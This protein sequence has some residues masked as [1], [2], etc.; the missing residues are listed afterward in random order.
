MAEIGRTGLRRQGG[1][2]SEEFLQE[3][4]GPRGRRA[5]REMSSNDAVVGA[6]LFAIEQLSRSVSWR[7]EPGGKAPEDQER[8]AFVEGCLDDMSSTWSDTLSEILS[9]LT[10]GFSWHE[11]VYKR[12][13][14]E[15]R[16]AT[17]RSAFNDGRIGWRKWPIRSQDSL[18]QWV[19]D[20]EGGVQGF[21]QQDP[22]A[23]RIV[24]IPIE[25][26]LLFRTASRKANPEGTSVLRT[27]Y[28][29]WYFSR[30]IEEIEAI[31]VSRDL[32]GY[33]VMQVLE[34]GPDIWNANDAAAV[35]LK[36]NIETLVRSISR[37]EQEGMVLPHW[38]E[39]KLVSSGSRRNFDTSGIIQRY[40]QRIAASMLADFILLG[41]EKVGSF[42]L[43]SSKT[44]L[45]AT[46][47]GSY[48]DAIRDVVNRHAIPRLLALNGWPT[49][50][51]PKLAHGDVE[52]PD[53]AELGTYVSSLAGAG[54]PLFPDETLER[55]LRAAA[56]LPEPDPD[57]EPIVEPDPEP[58]PTDPDLGPADEVEVDDDG[59]PV[60]PAEKR[61]RKSFYVHGLKKHG[62]HDQQSHAGDGD[63]GDSGEAA[64][65]AGSSVPVSGDNRLRSGKMKKDHE[66]Q[67]VDALKALRDRIAE[68]Q[69]QASD[70]DGTEVDYV[71]G[72]SGERR[73]GDDDMRSSDVVKIVQAMASRQAPSVHIHPDGDVVE[74]IVE[75][76]KS[77]PAPVVNV[78]APAVSV[79]SPV[80]NVEAPVVN[81]RA[82]V[83][84]APVV[85]V[86]PVVEAP[87]VSVNV[88]APVVNVTVPAPPAPVVHVAERKATRKRVVRGSDGRIEGLEEA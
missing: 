47:L 68:V 51:A 12:R 38:C 49:V 46:A 31:G 16:D 72:E 42:A 7:V 59:A 10:F 76:M 55:A 86:S 13:N 20:D 61:L 9:M 30:R 75:T 56:K 24:T 23:L 82:S 40:A 66:S 58:E 33:P 44:H 78:S 84:P 67:F 81:V 77:L 79:G 71:S 22:S 4:Q 73:A 60:P 63:G 70:D 5:Y 17:Q 65:V 83:V 8:A 35:Q 54:M 11:I 80:V 53:L 28:R 50:N 88:P 21:M 39:F 37:D 2:V 18:Y 41:H 14:G 1:V 27:A 34:S 43:S 87:A 85:N 48:L 15:S 74:R 62:D 25:K 45:F 19:F 26:S 57:R 29:S 6:V 52:T 32:A 36:Q 3:L 69:S 64:T